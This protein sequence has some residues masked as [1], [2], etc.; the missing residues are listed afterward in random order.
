M[1]N[2]QTLFNLLS[3]ATG[4]SSQLLRSEDFGQVSDSLQDSLTE[5]VDCAEDLLRDE[6]AHSGADDPYAHFVLVG[7]KVLRQL[8]ELGG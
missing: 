4:A 7:R 1:H 8:F 5:L 2:A 6:A 3:T